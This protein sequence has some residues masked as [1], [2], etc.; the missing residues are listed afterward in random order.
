MFSVVCV[1]ALLLSTNHA[2]AQFTA[3]KTGPEATR[4]TNIVR[5]AKGVYE[6]RTLKD[7]TVRGREDFHLTVHADGS[8]TM[9]AATD[10]TARDVQANVTLRVA[11]N[12]RPMDAY[13][14]LFTKA[15]Y[16]GALTLHV[17]G[18][19]LHAL[20]TGPAGRVAQTTRA[21]A[22][23]SFVT[24]PLALD[25][26]HPWYVTPTP[27]VEQKGEVYFL[28]TQG[29]PETHLLGQIQPQSFVY[30]GEDDV[31]VPAGTFRAQHVLM[32]GHSDIWFTGPDR[33]LVRYV[34]AAIDRDY[35]LGTLET[36][37]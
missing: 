10:I 31:T 21:P 18:D 14:T 22:Q 29:G 30:K 23:F 3:D 28:N 11:A 33:I 26:W 37:P 27:E 19:V 5:W 13:V 9:R 35:V 36:G 4:N 24:H 20:S 25:S 1:A 2:H 34:W 16:R 32:D 8:R 6:Y 17:A 7:Q 15:G 12:F